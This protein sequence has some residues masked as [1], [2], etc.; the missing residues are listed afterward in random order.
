MSTGVDI[1]DLEFVVF[2]RQVKSRI[3]FEQILGRG[4]RKGEKFLDKSHFT[5]FD[6][7]DGTLLAYFRTATAITAEPPTRRPERSPRSS[8]TSGRIATGTTTSACSSDD[9]T[10]S[11]RRWP[12]RRASS[13]LPSGS[14]TATSGATRASFGVLE[15]VPQSILAKAFRGELVAT[16]AEV[17]KQER[18]EYQSA[19][20]LVERLRGDQCESAAT[21]KKVVADRS[22][23]PRHAVR[24]TSPHGTV[25]R[26]RAV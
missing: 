4:T 11:T 26:R 16:E 13:S 3:L 9:C 18:R 25:R 2:L 21:R 7:F 23:R 14:L 10:A 17:A 12:A 19:S 5:V 24:R 22:R 1:P 8:T 6:C 20:V 15:T